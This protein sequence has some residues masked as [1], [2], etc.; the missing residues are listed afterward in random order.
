MIIDAVHLC[1]DPS[2]LPFATEGAVKIED[3]HSERPAS[4]IIRAVIRYN[5]IDATSWESYSLHRCYCSS[6]TKTEDQHLEA[7]KSELTLD[8]LGIRDG[9]SVFIRKKDDRLNEM[10]EEQR[11]FSRMRI[12][13]VRR[14]IES[15]EG[16]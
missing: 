10:E 13:H 11:E 15:G 9:E 14:A 4:K 6:H 16:R 3:L 12:E 7:F 2:H 5:G 1:Y 8:E